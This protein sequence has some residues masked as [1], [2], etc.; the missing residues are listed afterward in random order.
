MYLESYYREMCNRTAALEELLT[1]GGGWQ[2]SIFEN[3][4]PQIYE[5]YLTFPVKGFFDSLIVGPVKP[6]ARH[7]YTILWPTFLATLNKKVLR[8]CLFA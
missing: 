8:H 2:E 3:Y 1:R 4:F 5:F 7:E 6:S